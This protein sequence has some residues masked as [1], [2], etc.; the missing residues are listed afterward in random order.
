MNGFGWLTDFFLFFLIGWPMAV[1]FSPL[2]SYFSSW[3][4]TRHNLIKQHCGGHSFITPLL[5]SWDLPHSAYLVVY[6]NEFES[7]LFLSW[8]YSTLLSGP[9]GLSQFSCKLRWKPAW[10]K[11]PFPPS[12][13]LSPSGPLLHHLSHSS[14]FPLHPPPPHFFPTLRPPLFIFM[15]VFHLDVIR[16]ILKIF[17]FHN[18][19]FSVC[20]SHLTLSSQPTL[21]SNYP[22]CLFKKRI[23]MF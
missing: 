15:S 9:I 4:T 16:L 6:R 21:T 20:S 5:C 8:A 17:F 22:F 3:F 1:L 10:H 13:Y 19:L 12:L 11:L 14:L 7:G 23:S 18:M 2:V